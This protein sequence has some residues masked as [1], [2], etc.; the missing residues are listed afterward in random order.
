MTGIRT[1]QLISTTTRT[2]RLMTWCQGHIPADVAKV[3]GPEAQRLIRQSAIDAGAAQHPKLKRRTLTNLY[4]ER[5][6]WLHPA[7]LTLDR[8]V[9][10]AYAAT[11]PNA[12]WTLAGAEPFEETGA[13]QP[14]AE[15]HTLAS[16]P[17]GTEQLVLH[18]LLESNHKRQ[19][20]R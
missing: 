12:G 13:D 1:Q 4:N 7:H 11:D 2:D 6:A 18:S 17:A 10:N 8:A 20:P 16:R 14:L 5:P 9:L 15:G 3:S 19:E